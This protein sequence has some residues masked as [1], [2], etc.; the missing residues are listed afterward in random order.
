MCR[1][2]FI[3][4]LTYQVVKGLD[5]EN[6]RYGRINWRLYRKVNESDIWSSVEIKEEKK[7]VGFKLKS[8]VEEPRKKFYVDLR[9]KKSGKVGDGELDSVVEENWFR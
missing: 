6:F 3:K 8:C 7:K 5:Q 9:L 4:I 1:V 2:W